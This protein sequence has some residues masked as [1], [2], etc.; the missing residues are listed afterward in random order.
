MPTFLRAK[1]A[2]HENE[3][4]GTRLASWVSRRDER[5]QHEEALAG[6]VLATGNHLPEQTSGAEKARGVPIL[7]YGPGAIAGS[8]PEDVPNR[9]QRLRDRI[10]R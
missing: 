5:R 7:G 3:R 10:E 9:L 6:A 8:R 1:F 4:L 2:H